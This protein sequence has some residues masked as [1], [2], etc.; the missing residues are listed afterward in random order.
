MYRPK[1]GE[2][3]EDLLRFQEEFL[4]KQNVSSAKLTKNSDN[5]GEPSTKNPDPKTT[6]KRDVVKLDDSSTVSPG[7]VPRK[8]SKFKSSQ[9]E[10]NVSSSSS[11]RVYFDLDGNNHD[12]MHKEM[13]QRDSHITSV[14]SD[15]IERDIR[16]VPVYLPRAMNQA[17]PSAFHRGKQDDKRLKDVPEKKRPSLFAQHFSRTKPSEFGMIS[18]MKQVE[19]P[20]V[21]SKIHS[22]TIDNVRNIA[23]NP[24]SNESGQ[25]EKMEVEENAVGQM[26][27]LPVTPLVITGEGLDQVESSKEAIK[28]HKENLTKLSE[29]PEAE[30][31]AEQKQLKSMLDPNIVAFLASKKQKTTSSPSMDT[32]NAETTAKIPHGNEQVVEQT[33]S[34]PKS[35]TSP[36]TSRKGWVHMDTVEKE[37]LEWMQE[38]PKPKTGEKKIGVQAR[39]NLH[40][41][42]IA[43]DSDISMREGLHHHGEEPEVPGYTLEEMFQLCRSAALNQ[44]ILSLQI[45]AKVLYNYRLDRLGGD[46]QVALIPHLLDA[47]LIFI[48]RQ[49]LDDTSEVG[50]AAAV[51][52]F[53]SVLIQPADEECL[54]KVYGWYRGC[55]VHPLFLSKEEDEDE[56]DA[57]SNKKE[58]HEIEI[59]EQDVIK[60]LLKMKFLERLRYILEICR[61]DPTVVINILLLLIRLARHSPEASHEIMK[62]PRLMSTI[63]TMFL[64]TTWTPTDRSIIDDVYGFP[65]HHA[66]KLVRVLCMAGRNIAAII[67]ST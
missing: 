42:I 3:E 11:Q 40:G 38:V 52:A 18:E 49:S 10:S 61:P 54:D 30:I 35:G 6:L 48:L 29:M 53:K 59:L 33:M 8:K 57:D 9:R 13:D 51:D 1:P 4:R 44:R 7:D 20:N 34:S 65:V 26:A 2:T 36:I 16:D 64:P 55:E 62:C 46:L 63:F 27:S 19:V 12:N 28:I 41:V 25:E 67:V 32:S 15:I 22:K 58:K 66:M 17:F 60:G 23:K 14:L 50:I 24:E 37:K 43:R 21:T 47:G 5:K 56:E 39:F 31:L 45:L